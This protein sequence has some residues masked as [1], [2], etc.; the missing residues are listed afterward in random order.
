MR[1]EAEAAL[2]KWLAMADDSKIS[3]PDSSS[4]SGNFPLMFLALKSLSAYCSLER[5]SRDT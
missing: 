4:R 5:T 1:P 2:A 3:S